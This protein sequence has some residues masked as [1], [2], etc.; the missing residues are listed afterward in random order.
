MMNHIFRAAFDRNINALHTRRTASNC[1]KRCT[2]NN[3]QKQDTVKAE[4]RFHSLTLKI[5]R[6]KALSCS[7]ATLQLGNTVVFYY[8]AAVRNFITCVTYL[9]FKLT[10]L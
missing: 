2:Q 3:L 7:S 9:Y 5:H 1:I 10:H 6:R 8:S 4:T